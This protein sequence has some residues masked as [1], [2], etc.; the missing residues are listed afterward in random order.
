MRCSRLARVFSG[1][2]VGGDGFPPVCVLPVR[3]ETTDLTNANVIDCTGSPVQP[4]MTV[5]MDR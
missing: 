3:Q 5:V 4:G 1:V 2:D